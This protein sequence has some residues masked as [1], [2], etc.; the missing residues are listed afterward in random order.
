MVLRVHLH[1]IKAVLVTATLG[2]VVLGMS[3]TWIS[4]ER[5]FVSHG[6]VCRW[7][8]PVKDNVRKRLVGDLWVYFNLY[9]YAVIDVFEFGCHMRRKKGGASA[10]R[11]LLCS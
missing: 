8:G 2:E 1:L 6:C 9:L 11:R 5:S 3:V 7:V 4:A 10:P